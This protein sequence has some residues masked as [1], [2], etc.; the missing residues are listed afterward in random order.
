MKNLMSEIEFYAL[1]KERIMLFGSD[2]LFI[3]GESSFGVIKDSLMSLRAQ[4]EN[5]TNKESS[6][7]HP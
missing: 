7:S 6:P 5:V 4:K 3:G 1:W 2:T